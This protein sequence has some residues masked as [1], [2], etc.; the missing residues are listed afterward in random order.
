MVKSKQIIIPMKKINFLFLLVILAVVVLFS[1]GKTLDYYFF[2]DDYAFL[3]YL[4]NN[5]EFGWPYN[6]VLSIFSPIYK[7]F[8]T[9]AQ[10][11]FTLAVVT[12]FFASVSV[13]FFAKALTK[14]LLVSSVAS[15]IFAT[16]YIGLDQF[17]MIAVSIINNLNVINVSITLILLIY[18]I[19]T[20]KL[21]YY[22][23]TFFMFW[24]SLLLFPHRAYPLVLF[25]PSLELVLS[26]KPRKLKNMLK[27][28]VSLFLRYIPFLIV[29]VQRG[30][31]SY[32]THGTENVHLLNLVETDS[33]IYTLFN[34]LF[35]KELF[36]VLGKFVL[37]PSFTDFFKYVPSQDFYSFVGVATSLLAT[38]MSIVI[39][40]REK[41]KNGR[42][43]FAVFLL[44]IQSYAGNMFLNVDFDA[45]GPVN[46]Y[47]T[48]SFLFYSIL[49]SLFFYLFLQILS[50]I[51]VNAKK[52]IY[53]TLAF[54]LILVLASLSR[55]YEERVLEDRSQPAIK[56]F[57][58][59]KT[60][61]PALSDSN[62]NIFYF[63]RASYYP[64]SS[65]FGNVL[66]SAAMGNSVNLAFPYGISV[67]SV[68]ITDTFE[69]FLRLVF[70]T[71]EGKKPVYYTF[72]NDESGLKDTTDDVFS[73]LESGGSTVISSD[74]I[75]YKNEQGINAV[76]INTVGVSSL[77]PLSLRMSLQ[78]TPLP[79]SAFAFPYSFNASLTE[80]I[81][82]SEKEKIFKYLLS[83]EK[84]YESVRV[85]VE[86]IHV[87]KKNPA[88][89]LVDDNPDTNWI[90]DQSRWEVGI[91]PWIKIDLSEERSIGTALWRQSPSR[92][93]E[94]FTINVSSDGEN[95]TGVKNLSKRNI[96]SDNSLVA[97]DFNPVNARYVMLTIVSL[98]TGPGP[99]LAEIEL[100]EDE[101]NRMD[102]EK[103][104]GMKDN[105]FASISDVEEV[106]QAYAYLE[107][108]A[109]LK[110][111]T[112]TNKD[113]PVSSAVL[114]EIPIFLDGAYHDY[115][116]QIPQGGTHLKEIRLEANFPASFNVS[117]V[118]I[119]NLSKEKVLEETRK[120]CL[121]FTGIDSWRNPFDCS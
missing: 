28:V 40:R 59:L 24:F 108:N 84:Y 93:V 30:V 53:A 99:S 105:P 120:K 114:G 77:T 13:F 41:Q 64:V 115:E 75:T 52:R 104:F 7:L 85:Q 103:A 3:Y 33:K 2:T 61:V 83:R 38:A 118:L 29:A 113:D 45:N 11:Y 9:N 19:E 88:S 35:F 69:D 51:N 106:A 71:P 72:Y 96:Y 49:I 81:S 121:E 62:Y 16:G 78:A 14:N 23:L 87:G 82:E 1:L 44:T 91:K 17:S 18:W 86:S 97:V 112:F 92:A 25:L 20:R 95:W 79:P 70:Y 54:F 66:L 101:F 63:D 22:F 37:L 5:L 46:R 34:P 21:R 36:A 10:P 42:V 12:Y 76:S 50:K 57:K 8:G 6:S 74:K 4:G 43:I 94:D 102:I 90:S 110:I 107:K 60:Y 55:D 47:L 68:K 27:Q 111:K 56:F 67:D 119:E 100:L 58:E 109:K 39:Y 32:G 98:S 26:F 117:R 15:V 116:F 31:F 48:I 73:L 80:S 65:R 89:Y